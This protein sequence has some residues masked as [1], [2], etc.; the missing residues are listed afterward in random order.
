MNFETLKVRPDGDLLRV[1]IASPPLNL[2]RRQMVMD[3]FAV[4]G[5]LT[6]DP[7]VRVVVIDSAVEDFFI[8]HFDIEEMIASVNDPHTPQSAYPDINILQGLA[9]TWQGL[10]QV[11]VAKVAGICRGGGLEF[12]LGLDMRFASSDSRFCFPE[13]SGGFLAS[14]GGATRLLMGCGAARGLEILLTSRDFS[15]AEAERYGLINRALPLA[16][17]DPYVEDAVTRLARRSR[18]VIGMNKQ[19]S[20]AVYA[21]F[22]DAMF[23][24]SVP[25]M[26]VCGSRWRVPTF[27][28]FSAPWLSKLRHPKLSTICPHSLNASTPTYR[29]INYMTGRLLTS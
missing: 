3:L 12:T 4:A 26:M 21:S 5:G 10:P 19:V 17:L 13:A 11:T 27:T 16:E 25:K 20:R 15:G 9:T 8:A 1:S 14:G 7:S 29:S 28:S 23:A 22:A 2:M 6:T 24:G 18:R